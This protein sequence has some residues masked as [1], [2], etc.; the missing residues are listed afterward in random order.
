M[1]HDNDRS[2]TLTADLGV[3]G[4][5]ADLGVYGVG[6]GEAGDCGNDLYD[7]TNNGVYDAVDNG[8][9]EGGETQN[10]FC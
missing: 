4:T 5:N 6:A 9:E 1:I 2:G 7:I 8:A 3:Y 10:S